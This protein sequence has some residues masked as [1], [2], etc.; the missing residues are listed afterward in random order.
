MALRTVV[1]EL[2]RQ[3]SRD[4]EKNPKSLIRINFPKL[5]QRLQYLQHEGQQSTFIAPAAIRRFNFQG[6]LMNHFFSRTLVA[7][8]LAMPMAAFAQAVPIT[9]DVNGA[10][11]GGA[12]TVDLLDWAPGNALSVGGNPSSGPI[13]P[14]TQTQLLYQANLGLASLGGVNQ[15]SPGIN[16]PNFTAVAG[17]RE[18]VATN[19]AGS[20]TFTF[21]DAPVLSA[22]N[23][24]YIYAN[25]FGNNLAGTGFAPAGGTII[26]SGYVTSVL[27]SNYNT[28]GVIGPRLDNF[29]ADDHGVGTL[30]GSGATDINVFI[31]SVDA[32]YFPD[33]ASG[34]FQFS[35]FNN[36]QVTPFSQVD[37]SFLF[38]SN[39]L[40]DGN[41][42]NNIGNP[43]GVTQAVN[44]NFQ[45]QADANQSFSRLNVPEPGSLALVGLALGA[46]GFASRRAAKKA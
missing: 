26:M 46:L 29:G 5:A 43:N 33:F 25:A 42:A 31:D 22:T 36:S 30:V 6:Q 2:D 27:S 32:A 15:I 35:F 12:F 17:F 38:S 16:S 37:P 3:R 9:F 28:A 45:F 20:L 18:T 40:L 13:A 19:I 21:S 14:G 39:G 1:G 10:A 23:F 44:R 7:A 24:F 34:Q 11:P 8:A 41:L 4:L